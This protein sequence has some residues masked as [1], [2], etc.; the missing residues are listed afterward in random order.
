LRTAVVAGSVGYG[1][2]ATVVVGAAKMIIV[3]D[4]P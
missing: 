3:V 2:V 4:A 1:G